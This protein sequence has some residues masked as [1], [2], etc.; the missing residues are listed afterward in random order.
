MGEATPV[1]EVATQLPGTAPRR[2]VLSDVDVEAEGIRRV[3][4]VFRV[5]E[6]R[7]STGV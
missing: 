6:F 3:L 2:L 1:V 7:A 4:S 5:V